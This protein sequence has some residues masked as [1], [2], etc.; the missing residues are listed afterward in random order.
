MAK[1][2]YNYFKYLNIKLTLY[3]ALYKYT[4]EIKIIP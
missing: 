3:K 4:L 2:I 1:F